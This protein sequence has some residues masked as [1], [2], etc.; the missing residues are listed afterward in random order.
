[1]KLYNVE[2]SAQDDISDDKPL[3]DSTDTGNRLKAENKKFNKDVFSG[4]Q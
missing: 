2:Q 1:M 4:F 3:F